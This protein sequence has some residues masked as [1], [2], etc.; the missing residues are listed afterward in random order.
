MKQEFKILRSVSTALSFALLVA[1]CAPQTPKFAEA[2]AQRVNCPGGTTMMCEAK[3][4]GR[5]RHGTFARANDK[6]ACVPDDSRMI[7]SPVIPAIH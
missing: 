6:C 1:A 2:N 7:N 4:I 5:I 3:T